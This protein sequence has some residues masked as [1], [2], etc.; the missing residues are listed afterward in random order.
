MIVINCFGN[1]EENDDVAI[2][3]HD[4]EFALKAE[5]YRQLREDWMLRQT[6]LQIITIEE[7]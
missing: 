3:M 6:Q 7:K 4:E 5:R 2:T 1:D